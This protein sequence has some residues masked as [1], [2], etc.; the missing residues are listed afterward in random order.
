VTSTAWLPVSERAAALPAAAR[1]LWCLQD[2]GT[3]LAPATPGFAVL[4]ELHA[5]FSRN[6]SPLAGE[7]E[8]PVPDPNRVARIGLG[9]AS[10]VPA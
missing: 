3:W 6:S 8:M 4:A 2:R 10:G 5:W 9:S 7:R 1:L